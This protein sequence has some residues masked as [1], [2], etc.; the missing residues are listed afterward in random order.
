MEQ[1]EN[2]L[3]DERRDNLLQDEFA[4]NDE[5]IA[6]HE[7]KNEKFYTEALRN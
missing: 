4:R 2:H 6:R 3:H 5:A 1:D 7:A